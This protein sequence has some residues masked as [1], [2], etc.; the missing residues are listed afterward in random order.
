MAEN[1]KFCSFSTF[2]LFL[3]PTSPKTIHKKPQNQ[4]KKFYLSNYMKIIYLRNDWIRYTV[5]FALLLLLLHLDSKFNWNYLTWKYKKKIFTPFHSMTPIFQDIS[6]QPKNFSSFCLKKTFH[7]ENFLLRPCWAGVK[8]VPA[9]ETKS[10]L[11]VVGF[12]SFKEIF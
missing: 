10:S 5:G 11:D 4:E 7:D 12:V 3:L 2:W 1:C 8:S 6:Q 9:S